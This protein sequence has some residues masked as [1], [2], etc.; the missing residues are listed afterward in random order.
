[1]RYLKPLRPFFAW[2]QLSIPTVYDDSLSY[3]EVLNKCIFHFNEMLKIMQENY[4][5]IDEAFA[6]ILEECEA[7]IARCEEAA[8]RAEAAQSAAEKAQAA[9]EAAQAAAEAAQKLAE[10]AQAAAEAARDDAVTAQ[11]AAEAA[12][13]AAEAAQ[14]AAEAAQKKAETAQA[15]AEAAQA[16]AEDAQEKA[17]SARDA[18]QAAQTAAEAAQQKAEEAQTAAE[19]ARDAAEAAQTAAESARDAAQEAQASAENA[20]DEAQAAQAAAEAAQKKAE[21][22]QESAEASEQAAANSATNAAASASNAAASASNAAESASSAASDATNAAESA[23]NASNS[24]NQAAE[25]A[26]DASNS[27][28]AAHTSETNAADSAS[29][30]AES[31]EEIKNALDNYYDKTESDNTFVKKAGDTM[32][33]NLV[34]NTNN[35]PNNGTVY[36]AGAATRFRTIYLTGNQDFNNILLNGIYCRAGMPKGDKNYPST[37]DG[38][39]FILIVI[40]GTSSKI[41]KQIFF[42]YETTQDIYIRFSS[43]IQDKIQFGN[44]EKI[45]KLSDISG[46]YLPLSGGTMTGN[47]TMSNNSELVGNASTS[48][49]WKYSSS[50]GITDLND[51]KVP[52]IYHF[53][54]NIANSPTTTAYDIIS[55]VQSGLF[56]QV[57]ISTVFETEQYI[58]VGNNESFGKW[59]KFIFKTDIDNYLPLNGGTMTGNITMSNNSE[60]IGNASTSSFLKEN[61]IS[62]NQN[63]DELKEIGYYTSPVDTTNITNLPENI[64]G[65]NKSFS[66]FIYKWKK[67]DFNRCQ[68]LFSG[69]GADVLGIYFR[70][71]NN[72]S[73]SQTIWSDWVRLDNVPDTN[74]VKFYQ[75]KETDHLRFITYDLGNYYKVEAYTKQELQWNI[76]KTIESSPVVGNTYIYNTSIDDELTAGISDQYTMKSDT[77]I[78]VC[79]GLDYFISSGIVSSIS[80]GGKLGM[81]A[82]DDSFSKFSFEIQIV[83]PD[84]KTWN[85]MGN[86]YNILLYKNTLIGVV[87][88]PK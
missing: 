22:A 81:L 49:G 79:P 76:P 58:R 12:Q 68:L 41:V 67:T 40:A 24:A 13:A 9:A 6:K 63:M 5:I 62:S 34:M 43:L 87:I 72:T 3:Y 20:R 71:S 29:D 69:N 51:L 37:L 66:C 46:N 47:I 32:T 21:T 54:K 38:K 26:T 77:H 60:V 52:G 50:S 23:E 36:L 82:L 18:A 17:E 27:A 39:N 59:K 42:S 88:L 78:N 45:G 8:A 15:A 86:K 65:N 30:A 57:C 11:K 1:M 35:D 16:K 19:S 10:A 2:S 33:G 64:T 84:D 61:I 55:Y 85:N 31:A 80:L 28:D 83:W 74:T 7:A 56:I 70:M 73:T 44:W 48:N 4:E 25:S 75:V 53:P 14:A